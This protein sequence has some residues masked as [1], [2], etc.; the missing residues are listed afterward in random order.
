MS[1]GRLGQSGTVAARGTKA[2]GQPVA[3][4]SGRYAR[5]AMQGRVDV[6][7]VLW[8]DA[9]GDL[10]TAETSPS[11]NVHGTPLAVA[12]G[13]VDGPFAACGWPAQ[14]LAPARVAL[15][16]VRALDPGERALI[17]RLGLAAYTIADV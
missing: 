8:L 10:N 12:L 5:R 15:V 11:G 6:L 13:Q 17:R 7:R 16:G 14:A 9:H 1:A 2:S 4:R 3:A